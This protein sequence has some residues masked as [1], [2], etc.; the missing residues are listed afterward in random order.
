M[1]VSPWGQLLGCAICVCSQHSFAQSP[2]DAQPLLLEARLRQHIVSDGIFGVQCGER[3]YIPLAE[4]CEALEFP[5]RVWP[6]T[7]QAEG[8]FIEEGRTFSLDVGEGSVRIRDSATAVDTSRILIRPDD[9]FV[10]AEELSTWFPVDLTVDL[11]NLLLHIHSREPLP[12]EQ[13]LSREARRERVLISQ[14]RELVPDYPQAGAPYLW[15]SRPFVDATVKSSHS[16]NPT[17]SYS[18][19]ATAD[20]LGLESQLFTAGE[21]QKPLSEATLRLGRTN[22]DGRLLGPLRAR[23]FSLGD[24][25]TPQSALVARGRKGR[26]ILIS[27]FPL[28]RPSEFDRTTLRGEG[29]PGWEVEL[30]RNDALLDFQFVAD[31]G[32]YEFQDIP[33]L[34]GQ[35]LFRIVLYGPQGQRREECHRYYAGPDLIKP[36]QGHYRLAINQHEVDLIQIDGDAPRG[37]ARIFAEYDRGLNRH[38]SAGFSAVSLP[39]ERKGRHTYLGGHLHSSLAALYATLD[40]EIDVTGGWSALTALQTRWLGMNLFGE[41]AHF[42]EYESERITNGDPLEQAVRGRLDGRARFFCPLVFS[43]GAE[44]ERRQSG[45]VKTK[46]SG[47]LALSSRWGLL[48]NELATWS[49][50]G[51]PSSVTKTTTGQVLLNTRLWQHSLRTALRYAIRPLTRARSVVLS[52]DRRTER[53]GRFT[54]GIT[55]IL[56]GEKRISYSLGWHRTFEAL[57]LGLSSSCTDQGTVTASLSLSFSFGRDWRMRSTPMAAGGAALARVVLDQDGDGKISPADRPLPDVRLRVNTSRSGH[58]LTNDRGEVLIAGLSAHQPVHVTVNTDSFREP[59]WVVAPEG[60][61]LLPRPGST[62]ALDFL[63]QETGEIDGTIY[64]RAGTEV[65]AAPRIPMQLLD[66][67]GAVVMETVSA[68]DGFYMFDLVPY[69]AYTVRAAPTHTEIRSRTAAVIDPEN[70]VLSGLTIVVGS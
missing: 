10:E 11:R 4:W 51:G 64:M 57:T 2:S 29:T 44:Q 30:Y 6:D 37:D 66:A 28:D 24:L 15:V 53:H 68:Y 1:R 17:T 49:L 58:L 38:L 36:G 45:S 69:G 41:W 5:I 34:Y 25:F 21:R 13:R 47:H 32:R 60:F 39:I 9:L 43:L 27:S 67:H 46:A 35:N 55:G 59:F 3:I 56:E 14:R 40:T 62:A 31:D 22:P 42:H 23:L 63:V 70:P 26:G 18:A 65:R 61:T 48:T 8:W 12:M 33:V 19:F 16:S 7:G 50:V 52:A 20:L 54:L